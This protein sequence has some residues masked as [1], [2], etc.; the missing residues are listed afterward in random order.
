MKKLQLQN[1]TFGRLT[2][3]KEVP[4][5]KNPKWNIWE[6]KCICGKLT[7]VKGHDLNSGHTKSCGC[8]QVE[9]VI[10]KNTKYKT[11][12][13]AE[14][15]RSYNICKSTAK[16]RKLPFR[17]DVEY[18]DYI[19]KQ[20]CYYCGAIPTR[21]ESVIYTKYDLISIRN[22]IDRENSYLGYITDNCRP[23]CYECNVMKS[24]STIKDFYKR[25]VKIYN[26]RA[27]GAI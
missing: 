25:I 22:G 4:E 1:K 5:A 21:S 15:F 2:V 12:E 9:A 3:I 17:I 11:K 27:K 8:L 18:F 13:E 20:N 16:S 6:C 7:N 19:T 23:C 14:L 10:K 24:D 26:L